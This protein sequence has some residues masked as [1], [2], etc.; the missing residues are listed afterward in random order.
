MVD[1][2]EWLNFLTAQL[3]SVQELHMTILALRQ[4]IHN[5]DN[6]RREILHLV[7]FELD[8]T[9]TKHHMAP[10][11]SH[12]HHRQHW[13]IRQ[14]CFLSFVVLL[15]RTVMYFLHCEQVGKS[16]ICCTVSGHN[17]N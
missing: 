3:R 13:Q 11:P 15:T 7:N 14:T 17:L 4:V 12:P 8:V 1:I 10:L 9:A 16:S 5:I 6:L 2:D